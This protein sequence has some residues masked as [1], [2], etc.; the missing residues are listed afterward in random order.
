MQNTLFLLAIIFIPLGIF[1]MGFAVLWQMYIMFTETYTLNRYPS[2]R[3]VWVVASL[4]FSFSL[5][6]YYFCPNARKKGKWGI[7]AGFLGLFLFLIAKLYLL[8]MVHS[9]AT[10]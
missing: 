10:T 1:L 9:M 6:V 4:F 7:I 5:A 8:P 2:E 3:L